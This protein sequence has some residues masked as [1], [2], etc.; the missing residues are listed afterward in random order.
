[1]L[2]KLCVLVK[3]MERYLET[4]DVFT[5]LYFIVNESVEKQDDMSKVII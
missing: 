1:M 2:Y 5:S 3:R 4:I